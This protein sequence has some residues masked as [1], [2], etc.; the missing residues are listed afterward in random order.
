MLRD[1]KKKKNNAN[2]HLHIPRSINEKK[3]TTKKNTHTHTL[4]AFIS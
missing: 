2:A 3:I 1:I 4:I